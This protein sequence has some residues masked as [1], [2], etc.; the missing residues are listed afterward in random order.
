MSNPA[1]MASFLM[2][3]AFAA[4]VAASAIGGRMSCENSEAIRAHVSRVLD[5]TASTYVARAVLEDAMTP[6]VAIRALGAGSRRG[7]ALDCCSEECECIEVFEAS[8]EGLYALRALLR[9][10]ARSP[11][12]LEGALWT[13]ATDIDGA[14]ASVCEYAGEE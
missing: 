12:S 1:V 10:G 14:I 6:S 9:R 8:M 13:A 4:A 5:T 2:Y 11:E 7:F 3:V